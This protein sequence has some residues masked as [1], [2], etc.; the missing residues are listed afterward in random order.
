MT[1][2][3]DAYIPA[4]GRKCDRLGVPARRACVHEHVRD[5]HVCREHLSIPGLA[6]CL[7]CRE[8]G[9]DCPITIVELTP[10]TQQ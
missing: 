5:V 4:L 9:H 6:F 3:C 8:L 10:E 7:P 1:G 2:P